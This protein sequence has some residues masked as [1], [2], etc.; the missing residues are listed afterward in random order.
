MPIPTG[1]DNKVTYLTA[2]PVAAAD[3]NGVLTTANGAGYWC[4]DIKFADDNTALM[5]FGKMSA[6]YGYSAP[7]KVNEVGLSQGALD[8]DKAAQVLLGYWPTG[9]FPR[10][11]G[12]LF[13]LYQL[14]DDSG[15]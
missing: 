6:I 4:S 8:A 10:P 5:L 3:L 2:S 15:A 1:F 7:Q 9:V 12:T 13:V 14:I 11:D